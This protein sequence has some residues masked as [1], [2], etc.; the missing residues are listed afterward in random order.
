MSTLVRTIIGIVATLA[1]A[2]AAVVIGI[3]F[4]PTPQVKTE[5]APVL[6][7]LRVGGERS[8]STPGDGTVSPIVGQTNVVT[9]GQKGASSI[10][11]QVQA[12]IDAL[13][14]ADG[15]DPADGHRIITGGGSDPAVPADDPCS[16]AS[17]AP[18]ADCPDGVHGA[19]FADSHFGVLAMYLR[20][21]PPHA[22]HDSVFDCPQPTL[23]SGELLFDVVTNIPADIT[24]SYWPLDGSATAHSIVLHGASADLTAWNSDYSSHGNTYNYNHFIFQ[25]CGTLT[26]IRANTTYVA[27][28]VALD[29]FGRTSDPVVANFSSAPDPTYPTMSVIP[30]TNSL[31]YSSVPFAQGGLQPAVKAWVVPTGTPADCSSYDQRTQELQITQSEGVFQVGADYMRANNYVANFNQRVVDLFEAPEGSTIVVCARTFNTSAPSWDRSRPTTQQFVRLQSP[32]TAV[33]VVTVKRLHLARDVD[34]DAITILGTTQFGLPCGGPHASS[35]ALP[36]GGAGSGSTVTVN[37]VLCDASHSSEEDSAGVGTTGNILITTDAYVGHQTYTNR[38]TLAIARYDCAG[39]CDT[40]PP[41]LDY[42]IPL[43][44]PTPYRPMTGC[45]DP[46]GCSVPST[47]NATGSADI[48]VTW[49]RGSSNGLAHWAVGAVDNTLTPPPPPNTPQLDLLAAPTISLSPDGL[50]ASAIIPIRVDRHTHYR[51]TVSGDCFGS[52]A[53]TSY[54]GQTGTLGGGALQSAQQIVVGLCPNSTYNLMIALTDDAGHFSTYSS[55]S[56]VDAAH[57]WGYGYFR[58]PFDSIRI[59]ATFSLTSPTG[60]YRAW[61]S[62]GIDMTANAAAFQYATPFPIE[63]FPETTSVEGI[64]GLAKSATLPM[65]STFHL[66]AYGGI[67]TEGLYH[68]VNHDANCSWTDQHWYFPTIVDDVTYADLA[69]GLTLSTTSTP[70]EPFIL[71]MHL[72]ATNLGAGH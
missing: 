44:S 57:L 24:V 7:P 43:A 53:P 34:E 63:C 42:T 4:Q 15:I 62:T 54:T 18:A 55:S 40:L 9:P 2:T 71:S 45:T 52:G 66:N 12:Q 38:A 13:D 23:G 41:T 59:D 61:G 60:Y 65:A 50:S 5:T 49:L 26:G 67:I 36:D 6:G 47:A 30:L 10:G 64:T 17:G 28:A 1:V 56:P 35:M 16:P 29:S 11:S 32:D 48:E 14:A 46:S 27:S 25:H 51:L 19:V 8:P 58:T 31:L 20:A 22:Q 70:A 69:R 3:H 33:P 68:G 37:R 72:V 21:K 39:F